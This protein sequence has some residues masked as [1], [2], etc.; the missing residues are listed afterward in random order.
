M[1]EE[2]LTIWE[3]YEAEVEEAVWDE[4]EVRSYSITAPNQ[5]I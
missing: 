2:T 3:Y 4:V 5:D 1:K